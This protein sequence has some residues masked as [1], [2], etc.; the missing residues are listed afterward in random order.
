VDV[1]RH[2]R[3]LTTGPSATRRLSIRPAGGLVSLLLSACVSGVTV[4]PAAAAGPTL[5]IDVT[6]ASPDER[7]VG[8]EYDGGAMSGGG[9]GTLGACER[10]VTP[11]GE[12]RGSYI[13]TI[14]GT[15]VLDGTVPP[16]LMGGY[17]VIRVTMTTD[18]EVSAAPPTL[19]LREPAMVMNPIPGCS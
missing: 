4:E 14:D 1:A 5:V 8:Y 9:E 11:F 7:S 16:N 12:V 10:Q 6:N 15:S 17:L 2:G 18:G 3:R 13:V 19:V